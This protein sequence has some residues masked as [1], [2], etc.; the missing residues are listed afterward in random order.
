MGGPVWH[1][2]AGGRTEH[3]S[4][5][6]VAA[7]LRGVGDATLGEWWTAG[8]RMPIWHLKRRLSAAEQQLFGVPEP[9][10]IRD[11]KAEVE[12]L[13]VVVGEVPGLFR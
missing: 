2:S 7:G 4:K 11:T 3:D 9:V 8:D 13:L 1:A 12:R 5:Q 10:D 6:I